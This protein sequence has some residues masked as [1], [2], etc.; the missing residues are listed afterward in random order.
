MYANVVRSLLTEWCVATGQIPDTQ[1]SFFGTD[2]CGNWSTM[3][4][5]HSLALQYA[6]RTIKPKGRLARLHAAFINFKQAYDTVPRDALWK[7]LRRTRLPAPLLAVIRDM[8][9]RDKYV[10]KDGDKTARVHP[11]CGVKQG[12]PL[13]PLFFSLYINDIDDTAEGVSGAIT[14]TADMHVSHMLY[15]DDLN[16]LTNEPRD[17]QIMLSWLAKYARNKHLIVNTSKSEVVH[18]NSAGENVPVFYVG[19]ATLQHKDSFR[20]LGMVFHRT[21]N[22]AKSAEHASRPFL[23]SAYRIRS[24]PLLAC[25]VVKYGVLVFAGRQGVL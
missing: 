8:Y 4:H 12:C 22:M 20:Y 10:L 25:M 9:N 18:F 13:S 5:V 15:A 14:E 11:T 6:A 21:L 3:V 23:A 24:F 19:G 2:V 1:C 16:L 7:H 17:M